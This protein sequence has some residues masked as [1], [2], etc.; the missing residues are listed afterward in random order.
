[1][2]ARHHQPLPT[3]WGAVPASQPVWMELAARQCSSRAQGALSHLLPPAYPA[4]PLQSPFPDAHR[5]SH[6]ALP[7]QLGALRL[8]HLGPHLILVTRRACH[9]AE[10]WRGPLGA[11]CPNPEEPHLLLPLT[12]HSPGPTTFPDPQTEAA[13]TRA[14]RRALAQHGVSPAQ[15]LLIGSALGPTLG[16]WQA[17]GT[18][19]PRPLLTASPMTW[20]PLHCSGRAFADF[21]LVIFYLR[22]IVPGLSAGD[23]PGLTPA[24]G[25]SQ[26]GAA[27]GSACPALPEGCEAHHIVPLSLG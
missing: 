27:A 26:G 17:Q 8:V 14:R 5:D 9:R 3:P 2:G 12:P 15:A 10:G 25:D 23:S 7:T 11:A 18:L 16:L 13:E 6:P 19:S 1:M 21:C 4:A 20:L 22:N 24:Q